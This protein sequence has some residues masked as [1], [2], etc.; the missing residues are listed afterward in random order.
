MKTR[1]FILTILLAGCFNTVNAQWTY[2][3]A[4]YTGPLMFSYPVLTSYP[5]LSTGMPLE[6][7]IGYI[8]FDSLSRTMPLARIDSFF[9]ALGYSDT[10]KYAL[11]FAYEI[12]DYDPVSFSQYVN[13]QEQYPRH[14]ANLA[15]VLQF[16]FRSISKTYPDSL[17]S[18]LLLYN[19]DYIAHIRVNWT[20]SVIDTALPVFQNGIAADCSLIDGIKGQRYPPCVL[21]SLH[22]AGTGSNKA[23]STD[24][25]VEF[26]YRPDWPRFANV[27][28]IDATDS[29]LILQGHQWVEADSEYI[30]FLQLLDLGRDTSLN[31]STLEPL[32]TKNTMA[33]MY[34][35][36]GGIVFDPNNDFG[37]GSGL[38]ADQFKTKLRQKINSIK[39]P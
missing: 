2:R 33:G 28:S 8:Y 38:T 4:V 34:P 25:C 35:I 6:V 15:R 3:R 22:A 11:K 12:D 17:K 14:R 26:T 24:T 31:Y 21:S 37:F 29:T 36:R 5:P 32:P 9:N 23:L 20:N 39:N 7:L 30:V 19:A 27:H 13:N 18:T 10:L 1:Y 16:L